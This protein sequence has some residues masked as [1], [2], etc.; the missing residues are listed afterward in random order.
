[1][2]YEDVY[3]IEEKIKVSE[4]RYDEFGRM[5]WVKIDN[6]VVEFE[7]DGDGFRIKK[8]IVN[9]VKIYYWFGSNFIYESDVM[10]KGFSSIWGLSMIGRMDGSNIEYFMK[11]GYGDVFIMFDKS[12]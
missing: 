6:N 5:V 2:V 10:G 8:I 11:D 3:E 7:Y 9:D 4:F 12:G 1:M